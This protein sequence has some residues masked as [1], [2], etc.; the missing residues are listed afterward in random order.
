MLVLARKLGE[1]ILVG[2]DITIT[3]VLLSSGKV[4]IGIAAPKEMNIKRAELQP[5]ELT[6][7]KA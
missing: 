3:V 6:E 2:D 4:S 7:C 5:K 1:S